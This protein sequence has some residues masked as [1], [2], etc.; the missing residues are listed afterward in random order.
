M[1][2]FYIQKPI[3]VRGNSEPKKVDK[4]NTNKTIKMSMSQKMCETQTK[5]NGLIARTVTLEQNLLRLRDSVNQTLR[6]GS[7]ESTSSKSTAE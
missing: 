3:Q 6:G 5:W 1:K 2:S 7:K 4:S